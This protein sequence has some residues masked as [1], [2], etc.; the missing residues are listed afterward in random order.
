MLSQEKLFLKICETVS[1]KGFEHFTLDKTTWW[2]NSDNRKEA[3]EIN[4]HYCLIFSHEFAK[5]VWG[6][7]NVEVSGIKGLA[8]KYHLS[9]MA[10]SDDK[11]GYIAENYLSKL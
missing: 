7:G 3:L 8:W 6:E 9:L 5:F 1:E 2:R 11:L 10:Q 4:A